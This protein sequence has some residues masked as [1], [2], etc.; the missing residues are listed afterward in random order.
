[1]LKVIAKTPTDEPS[2]QRFIQTVNIAQSSLHQTVNAL[3]QKDMLYRVAFE[4]EALP[5]LRK[6]QLRVLDPLLAYALRKY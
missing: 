1:M 4:D 3:L 2:S 5:T 6:G